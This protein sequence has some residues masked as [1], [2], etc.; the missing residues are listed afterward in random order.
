MCVILF[1]LWIILIILGLLYGNS[2]IV[3]SIQIIFMVLLM[4]L[5][6]SSV[7]YPMNELHFQNIIAQPSSIFSG[8]WLYN[9]IIYFLGKYTSFAFVHFCLIFIGILLIVKAISK[10]TILKAEIFSLYMISPAIIDATQVRNFFAMSIWMNFT[11][12]ILKEKLTR[13]DIIFYLIGVFLASGIHS[14]FYVTLVFLLM[15]LVK[16]I[17]TASIIIVPV[18]LGFSGQN[19]IDFFM[20]KFGS[21]LPNIILLKYSAYKY[22]ISE[23]TIKSRSILILIMFTLYIISFYYIRNYNNRISTITS[24]NKN[25]NF[26][27]KIL[28]FNILVLISIPLLNFSL[29]F[30][31]IQRN[32]LILNYISL[33]LMNGRYTVLNHINF[34]VTKFFS[35]IFSL[36]IAYYYLYIDAIYNNYEFV[37]KML[38]P[39]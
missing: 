28:I 20:T 13:R 21:Y 25:Y 6:T 2:K 34:N 17:K 30:Y 29:E 26:S 14:S 32:L 31:R 33:L 19:F 27:K 3:L 5:N 22:T 4:G 39:Y 1:S 16:S 8:N 11:Y 15:P 12:F 18:I 36:A 35:V 37:F 7:D 9:I 10:F 23:G 24:D 38:F